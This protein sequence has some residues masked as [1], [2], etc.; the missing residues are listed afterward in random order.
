M[1][2]AVGFSGGKKNIVFVSAVHD[3]RM[4][5]RG[6][7]QALAAAMVKLGHTV[8][9]VSLRFSLL[10]LIKGDSRSSL[11]RR[12][13]RPE[14]IDGVLCYLWF[15]FLH[16]FQSKNR[17]LEF[18]F[19]PHYLLHKR[20]KNS[21]VDRCFRKADVIV[22]ESGQGILFAERARR[23]NS[24]AKIIYRASDKLSTIG[25]SEILQV[26]LEKNAGA[27]DWFCLLSA[28]MAD[29]FAWA[30]E[31]TFCVPLGIDPADYRD[32]GPNPYVAPINAVS[33]GSMLFDPSFFRTAAALFPVIQFH[34]IGCGARFEAPPNVKL[35]DEMAFKDTLRYIEH[36]SFGIAPYREREGAGYL[37][38]SSLKLKQYEY[39]GIPAVCPFFAVGRSRN[40]FGYV[41]GDESSIERAIDQARN[42]VFVPVPAPL[43]WQ[44]LALRLLDPQRFPDCE[45][46]EMTGAESNDPQLPS[47]GSNAGI[48][49]VSLV[50]CT[51]GDRKKQLLRLIDSLKTQEFTAF[52]IILVDQN[53][54]GYLDEILRANCSCVP[55]KHVRSDRGLS[56]GRN[57]GLR[58]ALGAIVGFPDDDCWYVPQT[59]NQVASF[60]RRNPKVDILLGRTVDAFGAPSLS[61]LRKRSGAVNRSN[62]WISGNSNTLFVRKEVVPA[63]GF[64]EKL[65]VGA[66]TRY[67]SGEETDFILTLMKNRARAVYISDL[68]ICHD[69]VDTVGTA[70]ILKRA[71]MY[72]LGFGYVLKKHQFGFGYLSY[73]VVRSIVGAM[74]AVVGLRPVY[75]I[76]RMVWSAGT[77][78]GYVSAKL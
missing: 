26:E 44:D 62:V 11:W 48:V 39:M 75:G 46:G 50:I 61:P 27:F 41:P 16:P 31:K 71:W 7:I 38:T 33:V 59:L 78:V 77:L 9:F 69:Q 53:S 23:L 74:R 56:I 51:L 8:T 4:L 12:A 45:L 14:L 65:G 49:G 6:S 28:D 54:P 40:R 76:G 15:T 68:K 1:Q 2:N 24:T 37:A 29:E 17:L 58:H 22:I 60:F 34:L 19:R 36:A 43:N 64:D 42:S 25:A 30:R 55:L 3:F 13:N 57:V 21:F 72:S 10:S 66:P 18:L 20:L 47:T 35:Y 5:R 67:Q 63:H 70:R 73:R 52:E 32:N